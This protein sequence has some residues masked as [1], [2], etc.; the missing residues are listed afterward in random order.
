[1]DLT[2]QVMATATETR[3]LATRALDTITTE[4]LDVG[5]KSF[6]KAE[7]IFTL[8]TENVRTA[9]QTL[10]LVTSNANIATQNLV[11]TKRVH[12]VVLGVESRVEALG[13]WR[14]RGSLCDEFET[15]DIPGP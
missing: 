12:E 13:K 2:T 6:N 1:M 9:E 8:T 14:S 11:V 10:D 5:T 4:V 7:E 3:E 15:D